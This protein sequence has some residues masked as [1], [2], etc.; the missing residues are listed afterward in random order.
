MSVVFGGEGK[1]AAA[2]DASKLTTFGGIAAVLVL[3]LLVLMY[4]PNLL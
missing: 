1:A 2:A 4:Y 3:A